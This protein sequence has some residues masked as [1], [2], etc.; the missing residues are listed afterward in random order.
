MPVNITD[1]KAVEKSTL[2][3]TAAF[4]DEDGN[5]VTPNNITWTWT[6]ED[7][8][9]INSREDVVVVTPAASV[10]IVLYGDDLQILSAESA[11][12]VIRIVTLEY[13][14]DSSIG[15]G[16]PN[17]DGTELPGKESARILLQN[18]TAVS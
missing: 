17:G 3:V 2:I 9:V 1:K 13:D 6:D 15:A 10:N 11:A 16:G 4:T 12:E 7:G 18:L 5:A 8:T 14:Y